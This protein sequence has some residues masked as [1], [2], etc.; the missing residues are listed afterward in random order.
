MRNGRDEE[1][2]RGNR[3]QQLTTGSLGQRRAQHGQQELTVAEVLDEAIVVRRVVM[4]VEARVR[5][6][7]R[8]K[9]AH[10]HQRAGHRH[11]DSAAQREKSVLAARLQSGGNQA[12]TRERGK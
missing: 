11:R 12:D 2:R 6:G 7:R 10:H 8:C 4:R 5:L 3:G 9:E 1:R